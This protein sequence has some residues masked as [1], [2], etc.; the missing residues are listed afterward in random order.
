MVVDYNRRAAYVG[1]GRLAQAG[2][3]LGSAWCGRRLV[4]VLVLLL[5]RLMVVRLLLLGLKRVIY[6]ML[7]LD[8]LLHRII[9]LVTVLAS[10]GLAAVLDARRQRVSA[11]TGASSARRI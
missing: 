7:D 4:E 6:A 10:R 1:R 9:F 3:A 8:L 2:P 5:V 11:R